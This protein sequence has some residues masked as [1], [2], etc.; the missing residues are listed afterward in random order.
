M[1]TPDDI[2]YALETT[3][4]L[5]EPDHRIRTFGE[6]RFEFQLISELMDRVGAVRIRS[7]EVEAQRPRV[8]RPE[9][10]RGIELDGFDPSMRVRMERMIEKF[11]AEGRDLAFLQY[12]FQFRRGEVH[13]EIIHDS[14]DAVRDRVLED[15]RRNG[16]PALAVIEGV[17]D[18]WEISVLKFSFDMIMK[19]HEINA[20]DF[21]RKGI[22]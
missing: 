11:R 7:G 6:T 18:A 22:L 5:R 14:V 12:G 20:F 13:E 21:R 17:D 3:R 2:H 15:I 10:Y 19:S 4:V 8:L 16:N 1:H 9:P